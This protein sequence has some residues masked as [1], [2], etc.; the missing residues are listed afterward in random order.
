MSPWTT[1][2]SSQT[3]RPASS[4]SKTAAY[5][6][7]A[8][9][10]KTTFQCI[11]ALRLQGFTEPPDVDLWQ[12]SYRPRVHTEGLTEPYAA[13]LCDFRGHHGDPPST[14]IKMCRKVDIRGHS[15]TSVEP[16]QVPPGLAA[17][18]PGS[19]AQRVKVH[20][21]TSAPRVCTHPPCPPASPTV[22]KKGPSRGPALW[23]SHQVHLRRLGLQP[24]GGFWGP[25]G[26]RGGVVGSGLRP[27]HSA[28]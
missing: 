9:V 19:Q 18:S 11:T 24:R 27:K 4:L 20:A 13:G 23:T 2:L 28:V 26:P 1:H 12:R 3:C 14:T 25:E 16:E 17:G 7:H 21:W 15:E 8:T 5:Q 10:L 6:E 22:G